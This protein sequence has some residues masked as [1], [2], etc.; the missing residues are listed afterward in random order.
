MPNIPYDE[1]AYIGMSFDAANKQIAENGYR[2]RLV[3]K[4]GEY[5]IC[6]QEYRTDRINVYVENGIVTKTTL[7]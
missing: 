5:F 7:G 3:Y 4:D 2:C 6:T 1:K